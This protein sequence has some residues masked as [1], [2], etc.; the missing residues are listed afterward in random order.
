MLQQKWFGSNMIDFP[1][2]KVSTFTLSRGIIMPRRRLLSRDRQPSDYRGVWNLRWHAWHACYFIPPW[3]RDTGLI[4]T[5][6]HAGLHH[7]SSDPSSGLSFPLIKVILTNEIITP[8]T[9]AM[10]QGTRESSSIT[11][12]PFSV[13]VVMY[14]CSEDDVT[15]TSQADCWN[16]SAFLHFYLVFFW[17]RCLN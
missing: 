11:V 16:E 7:N 12:K 9:R 17:F 1:N 10:L 14:I 6:H 5:T 15:L 4:I 3:E 13:S 2:T 8:M